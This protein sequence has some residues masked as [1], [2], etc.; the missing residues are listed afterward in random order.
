MK[1]YFLLTNL[2]FL[3]HSYSQETPKNT[4]LKRNLTYTRVELSI[5][6]SVNKYYGEENETFFYLM[7]LLEGLELE[8]KPITGFGLEQISELIGRQ[9]NA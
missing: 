6:L 3:I 2:F 4:N 5:P 8:L 7:E 9:V 1:H